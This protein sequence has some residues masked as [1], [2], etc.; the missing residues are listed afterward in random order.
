MSEFI[1]E[2]AT[3][4]IIGETETNYKFRTEKVI[5]SKEEAKEFLKN[6][7][8][9]CA[10][11]SVSQNLGHRINFNLDKRYIVEDLNKKETEFI[12]FD[13]FDEVLDYLKGEYPEK[14]QTKIQMEIIPHS[15]GE[16]AIKYKYNVGD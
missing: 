5:I 13:N 12:E 16:I 10:V 7:N 4:K 9:H 11:G 8:V 6:R 15:V 14:Q 2:K 3:H 1:F